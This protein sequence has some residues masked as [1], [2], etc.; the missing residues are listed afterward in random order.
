MKGLVGSQNL[1][2]R[3]RIRANGRV[4]LFSVHF[5]ASDAVRDDDL[6]DIL[7]NHLYRKG[8]RHFQQVANGSTD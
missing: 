3:L 4:P 8:F 1:P 6:L 2:T 7:R 5:R